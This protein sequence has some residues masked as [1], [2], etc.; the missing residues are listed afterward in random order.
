MYVHVWHYKHSAHSIVPYS[1]SSNHAFK[2]NLSLLWS[3][4]QGFT[5]WLCHGWHI[6][7][8]SWNCQ[9]LSL[10]KLSVMTKKQNLFFFASP[11]DDKCTVS[12]KTLFFIDISVQ[13]I[14]AV[15]SDSV[16]PRTAKCQASL[17]IT[18]SK[19]LF[20]F[21][22]IESVMPFNHL[23]LCCPIL[24]LFQHQGLFKWVRSLHQEA[25]E[26]EF[27]LQYQSFQWIFRTDFL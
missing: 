20:K 17:S 10:L 26:L 27:Q 19:S 7:K 22:S 23:I 15:L 5:V 13:F 9:Q 16:N 3:W 24:F 25:K 12:K 21:M 4:E 14:C 6:D 1:I 8:I 2:R 11:G 18:N